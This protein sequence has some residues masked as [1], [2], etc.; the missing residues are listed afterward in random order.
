M[1]SNKDITNTGALNYRD[2]QSLNAEAF[3]PTQD[4]LDFF[5]RSFQLEA[6][7]RYLYE[8][9]FDITPKYVQSSLM[10]G[11]TGDYWGNSIF[12]EEVSRGIQSEYLSDIRAK[13]QPWFA[14]L[15]AGVAKGVALAGTTYLDGTIG[16]VAGIAEGIGA[17]V[18]GESWGDSIAKLWNNEVS[19]GLAS[20]NKSL[21]EILPNY[22]TQ[23]EMDNPWYK[24]LGTINFWADSVIKNL[25]FTV[26]A[27][28]SGGAWNKA[29]KAVGA[30]KGAMGAKVVGSFLSAVNEGRIEA[31]HGASDFLN[32]QFAQIVDA[33]GKVNPEIQAMKEY[34]LSDEEILDQLSLEDANIARL[35][36]GARDRANAMGLA[37]LIGNTVLL[38]L[39][40]FDT[41]GK[42]Y[43]R[44]FK[45]AET[46]ASDRIRKEAGKYIFDKITKKEAIARGIK[47][48]LVEGNEEMSQAFIS[49]TA[50][51]RQTPDSPDAYYEALLDPNA[52]I[53]TK[54]FLKSVTEGF[55]NTYGNG[56]RWEEFAIGAITGL[57]GIPTFGKVQNADANT[58]LGR[59]K[60]VGISG[61]IFGEI[62][63][64]NR[65]NAEGQEAVDFM[66]N[67]AQK[68]QEQKDHFVRSQSFTN[69]MDG[70]A[71]DKNA[72]EYKNAEDNSDFSA[73]SRFAKV[74]RLGDLKEMVNQDFENISDEELEKI[75]E[76][77]SPENGVG[78]WRNADG[79][80]MSSTEEGK[81]EMRREL[82]SKRD[83]ILNEI[84][85]YERSVEEVRA[86]GNNSLS[87]DQVNELAW[88]N[89][90][91]GRFDER[92]KSLKEDNKQVFTI[93]SESL[94][95]FR[96]AIDEQ[97][98][99]GGKWMKTVNNLIDFI[100]YLQGAKSSLDLATRVAANKPLLDA[101]NSQDTFDFFAS[102][103]GMSYSQY[104]N[105]MINLR[106]AGK[107]ATAAQQ[108]NDRYREFVD[109]PTE[110]IKNRESISKRKEKTAQA[111]N[112]VNL[113]DQV[114]NSSVSDIVQGINNGDLNPE[115]LDG[116][117]SDEDNAF[118][119][120]SVGEPSAPTG[121]QKVEEA[122][123]IVQTS[124]RMSNALSSLEDESVDQQTIRDAIA[125]MKHSE[126]VSET[127]EE[128]LDTGTQAFNDPHNL[129]LEMDEAMVV[130]NQEEIEAILGERID[131]AKSAIERAKAILAEEDKELSD[132]PTNTTVAK[133]ST[134]D[135][136][137]ETKSAKITAVAPTEAQEES[138]GHDATTKVVTENE[139]R[140]E[141]E[142]KEAAQK[143]KATEQGKVNDFFNG[144]RQNV[145]PEN[146]V[147]FNKSLA[148][149][150]SNID[151]LLSKNTP[152][153][154]LG[155]AIK[156]TQSYKELKASAPY[157]PV[158]E[159]L[160]AY[161]SYK[162]NK[163]TS[164][165]KVEERVA[166]T[167]VITKE[168]V[169]TQTDIQS[170]NNPN[171]SELPQTY[172]YWKPAL[173]Y[174]P[175]GKAY[176]KGN[177]A[178]FHTIARSLKNA[179]G[180]PMF[181]E[182][183]L[184]RI[185][186]VGKYLE[187]H[188]TFKL[189][190]SG[191]VKVGDKIS[192][193]IDSTLNDAAGEVVILMVDNEGRVVGDVMSKND[194]PFLR[195]IY[196]PAFVEKVMQ[197][198]NDAG[199]PQYFL[200]S[201]STVVDKN[202]V[203][204]VPYLA[205]HNEMNTLNAIHSDGNTP[206]PFLIGVAASSGR[207]ARILASAGRTKKQGQSDLERSINPPLVAKAGQPFLLMP[208]SSATNHYMPV[209][210]TMEPYSPS[211]Q[212]TALGQAIHKVLERVS[213]ADNSNAI[214]II[215]DL[216]ELIS[217]QE[218]HINYS[219][220]NVKVTI[221]PN[222]AEH[223]MTIYN[224][225]KN[226]DNIVEQLE[227]GLQG[228]PFQVSRKYMNESYNGQD[229]NR[230]IGEIAKTNLPIGATHTI[231]DWFTIKPVDAKGN[232]A[233]AK[234]PRSTG[235]NPHAAEVPEIS[236][237]KGGMELSVNT[238]T[239]EVSDG[240]K[241]Y[242]GKN[243][244]KV[245]AYAFGIHTNKNMEQPY[246]TEWGYYDP[247]KDEFVEKPNIVLKS[248]GKPQGSRKEITYTPKGK[249]TQTYYIEGTHIYNKNGEEVFKEDSVD[250]NKIFANLAVKEGRAKVV[251]HKG[252]KY[253]VNNKG[254]IISV[255]TGKRMQWG[256]ENGDRKAILELAQVQTAEIQ[257]TSEKQVEAS[258]NLSLNDYLDII[259]PLPDKNLNN[260]VDFN[261]VTRI[262]ERIMRGEE[263]RESY[264]AYSEDLLKKSLNGQIERYRAALKLLEERRKETA[265]ELSAEEALRG[266]LTEI[267][268]ATKQMRL[269]LSALYRK[270]RD[271]AAVSES[272]TREVLEE[273]PE[274]IKDKA[275]KAGL[276]NNKVREALWEVLSPEQQ[277]I[278]ANKKGPKQK[279][280]MDV[281]EAAWMPATQEFNT[282]ILKGSVDDLLGRKALYRVTDGSERVWNR[283]KEL[284]W[285]KKVLPNLSTEE[286]LSIVDGLI[287]IVDSK[288][289]GY[290]YGKFQEG[291]ITISDVAAR[292]TM[293]HEAFHAVV[294]TLLNGKE[295]QKLL[296][297]AAERWSGLG[298]VALEEKLAEDF[299]MFMQSEEEWYDSLDK[300]KYGIIRKTLAT[301]YHKLQNLIKELSGKTPYINKLYY[302]INR[303]KF[304]RRKV[305][306]S[307]VTR[308]SEESYTSEMQAIK[309]SAIANNTFM[310]APNG[311]PTNLTERQW[312]QVR[313]KA[314]INW[315]GDWIN[316]PENA[317]KVI[318]KNGEPLVVYRAGEI[319]NDG[320]IKSRYKAYYFTPSKNYAEQ[321]AKQ[322]EVPIHSFFLKANSINDIGNGLKPIIRNDNQKVPKRGLFEMPWSNEDVNIIL[323]GK[324]AAYSSGEYLIPSLSQI[325]SATDNIG[326]FSPTSDD[327]RYRYA[328]EM[329]ELEYEIES[330]DSNIQSIKDQRRLFTKNKAAIKWRTI[331][332]KRYAQVD[333]TGY[334]YESEAIRNIPSEYRDVV[335]PIGI[336]DGNTYRYYLHLKSKEE[337]DKEIKELR[338]YQE[339]LK[340]Q[341]R[342]LKNN[343]WDIISTE[344]PQDQEE[345]HRKIEQY[346]RDKLLYDNLSQEN[347]EYL[348]ERGITTEEFKDMTQLEKEVLFKCKY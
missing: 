319:N 193:F 246:D 235:K 276:L 287:E 54:S 3:T 66:N 198:Y 126:E 35:T 45:N 67:Y 37:T 322:E 223:Q 180:T 118:L 312:L 148:E 1:S 264:D 331:D 27:F 17:K 251:E 326:T 288:K 22:R 84:D 157:L 29:L 131:S 53:E 64:A 171:E 44:G 145:A 348:Q 184:R 310:K 18:Q 87:E 265:G 142:A 80:L 94:L 132:L 316:N 105:A 134:E 204:K 123:N 111:V 248:I 285:M 315:F 318:D 283:D 28:Y 244:D 96:D 300:K 159:Y 222:G 267:Q 194:A 79:S 128:L 121:K 63:T 335:I 213:T 107:L 81:A 212:G 154:E 176:Q 219:G 8:S 140:K 232:I 101:L 309:D 221:K 270:Q 88:L 104:T 291:M 255:T 307:G 23:A 33:I 217:V 76:F 127:T 323:E 72:F 138:T 224:G 257:D 284:S 73:I 31:N 55:A 278:I 311:S 161:V 141:T 341:L 130:A 258:T 178:P 346:H 207:N 39:N 338:D 13:N 91:I 236:V 245:K 156:D 342:E 302:S 334:L 153:K 162:T 75:A 345:A 240:T 124:K 266:P 43:A 6:Q 333:T 252:N 116:L 201:L 112:N 83:K 277:S 74:G 210:I 168:E 328:D 299:R 169:L 187:E 202:M 220:D 298:G 41:F 313:T 167:P 183:Q 179:N 60:A 65:E 234:S 226:A 337:S 247:T 243:A 172:L 34:G 249:S 314:F 114:N 230:M 89:W 129:E 16:L 38:S 165:P 99:E 155:K 24:N 109:N 58:W 231:S 11:G 92:F 115:E 146:T 233:K 93:L 10:Q 97:S 149:V 119:N 21:E 261:T 151:M 242:E 150:V 196:L 343:K 69:A 200:S 305:G 56:D 199:S 125:L 203:G 137:D 100:S 158:E 197:E 209:P 280:W 192:F 279:Q 330:I 336:Y 239:W 304:S 272:T 68:V 52:E 110:L 227:L 14:K 181:T 286:H 275:K 40:N 190:D 90:K 71:E 263:H 332:K 2:L 98:E 108:F 317:S 102:E 82:S 260:G 50:G 113:R 77:S 9:N 42:L 51:Q 308:F 47:H 214:G 325:K 170:R 268:M 238:K 19:N 290:A 211:T 7:K 306:Q 166:R 241:T 36:E 59:G 191:G 160:N 173:S 321:Y 139:R 95:D 152:A 195:Q 303:G 205:D 62:G 292:G 281:L 274:Q 254:D 253:V 103:V 147:T 4:D 70:W 282:L 30:V 273:T 136:A 61:G 85:R 163:A 15:G 340:Q 188:G 208:T 297:A 344:A 339:K 262:R 215:N 329:Y 133:L 20:L 289:P 296:D 295:Y 293:Y 117:F 294:H 174:L 182:A 177:T 48:G 301:L 250:R 225:P 25:G 320:T 259:L 143:A 256:P 324:E 237:T 164:T 206:V 189:V 5:N 120:E 144:L 106:D 229:Y 26:G 32:L 78:G 122:K 347:K 49:E 135:A 218:I 185:E 216:E 327:I 186:A 175:F 228:Q 271:T 86:I 269:Y 46:I 57:F 12:D